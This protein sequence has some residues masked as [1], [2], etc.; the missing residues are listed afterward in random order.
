MESHTC[1]LCLASV[2]QRHT[3]IHVIAS[4]RASLLFL[5]AYIPS[6]GLDHSF[7]LPSSFGHLGRWHFLAG[8]QSAAAVTFREQV[9]VWTCGRV[10]SALLGT[11][12]S[13][14]GSAGAD[15]NSVTGVLWSCQTP[16]H[17]DCRL[18]VF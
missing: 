10:S 9:S 18:F 1:P 16:F 6:C 5:A 4:V 12:T 2:T 3:S 8:V 7:F 14:S 17:S 15:G 13:S 11:H